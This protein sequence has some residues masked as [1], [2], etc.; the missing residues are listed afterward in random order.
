VVTGLYDSKALRE[1]RYL[2]AAAEADLRNAMTGFEEYFANHKT[3][4][5]SVEKM[6]GYGF[7]QS[8]N[9]QVIVESADSKGYTL[10]GYHENSNHELIVSGPTDRPNFEKRKRQN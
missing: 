9:V 6:T 8:K 5:N 7:Y 4:P 1:D 2:D 3:Y 10:R